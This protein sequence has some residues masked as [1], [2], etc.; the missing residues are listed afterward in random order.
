[1]ND[2]SLEEQAT[3]YKQTSEKLQH[4]KQNVNDKRDE[5]AAI[6]RELAAL[7]DDINRQVRQASCMFCSMLHAL[8]L[9]RRAVAQRA[10]Q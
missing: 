5:V 2:I 3:R 4:A 8:D 9:T 10:A 1:M 6:E 7:N